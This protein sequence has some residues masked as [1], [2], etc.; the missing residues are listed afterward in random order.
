MD[1]TLVMLPPQT[2]TTR[3]WASRLAAAVPELSVVV[4]E[5]PEQ[6]TKVVALCLPPVVM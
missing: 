6:A 4:T 5:D 3:G 1:A 2:P